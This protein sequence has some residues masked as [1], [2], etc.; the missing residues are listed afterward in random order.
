[1]QEALLGAALTPDEPLRRGD[2]VFWRSH[3]AWVSDPE[4]IL[5]ANG[6]S[7]SVAY[8]PLRQAVERIEAQG[9]GPVTTYRRLDVGGPSA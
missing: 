2:L 6:G 5:H 9:E 3:V 8:E 1:M 7:M 4:T